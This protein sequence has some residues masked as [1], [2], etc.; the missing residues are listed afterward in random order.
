MRLSLFLTAVL[1]VLLGAVSAWGQVYG[2][3]NATPFAPYLNSVFPTRAPSGGATFATAVAFPNLTFTEPMFLTPYPGSNFLMMVTK[4][5]RIYRFDNH[6]SVTNAELQTFLDI[7]TPATKSS[8]VVQRHIG[9]TDCGNRRPPA[10]AT[11]G[12]CAC[13][14]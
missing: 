8:A 1:N 14:G 6:G 3:D 7:I 4:S 13:A 2:L 12:V 5:G 11:F 9:H 10:W